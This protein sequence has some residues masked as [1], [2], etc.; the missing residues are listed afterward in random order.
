MMCVESRAKKLLN[1]CVHFAVHVKSSFS[2]VHTTPQPCRQSTKLE[3]MT[4]SIRTKVLVKFGAPQMMC[5]ESRAKKL[6]NA[7]VHSLPYM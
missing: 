1:A 6:L 2:H 7:C 3:S 5:V 4:T